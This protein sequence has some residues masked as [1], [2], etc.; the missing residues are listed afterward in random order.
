MSFGLSGNEL[1]SE[2]IG[3]DVVVVWVDKN[4]LKG[5]AEDYY[6]DDK[7]Q[8][9]GPKGSCPDERLGVVISRPQTI[10]TFL[11]STKL[12]G[13]FKQYPASKRGD[14][15][16]VLHRHLPAS[17][18]GGRRV[19]QANLHQQVS[20]NNLGG[21]TVE[22]TRRGIVPHQVHQRRPIHRLRTSSH[23]ELP[24]PRRRRSHGKTGLHNHRGD[25]DATSKSTTKEERWS[26]QT[27]AGSAR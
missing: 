6:L 13:T 14:G 18:E 22:P 15:E 25:D 8:C 20:G 10:P 7:S 12:S 4:S 19:R 24:F 2:M 17:P 16:R 26:E 21:G 3:G 9:S 1:K 5:Y 23:M 11:I 27:T